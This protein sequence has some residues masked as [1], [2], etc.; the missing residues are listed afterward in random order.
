MLQAK[1]KVMNHVKCIFKECAKD[2][3]LFLNG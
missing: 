3:F 2:V 1:K